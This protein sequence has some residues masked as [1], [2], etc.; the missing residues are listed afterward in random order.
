VAPL[1]RPFWQLQSGLPAQ[2]LQLEEE[3]LP[4]VAQQGTIFVAQAAQDEQQEAGQEQG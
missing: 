4:Q 2:A 1:H 3:Q